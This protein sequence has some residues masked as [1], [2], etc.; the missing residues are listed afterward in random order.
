MRSNIVVCG[1]V[2]AFCFS[3]APVGG[4]QRLSQVTVGQSV[5]G[6][7]TPDSPTF[8]GT[9]FQAFEFEAR[10]G[11]T[12][13]ALA[14]ASDFEPEVRIGRWVAGVIDY[15]AT[16]GEAGLDAGAL[17]LITAS[18][19]GRHVV[20]VRSAD[21]RTGD[22]TLQ[23]R[24]PGG[25][26]LPLELGRATA[27]TVGATGESL[28][29]FRGSA[30]QD[31]E[32]VVRSRDFDT[33]LEVGRM[34]N[35][36][37]M[38][39]QQDDDG[40]GGTDSRVYFTPPA[41][42]EYIARVTAYGGGEGGAYA[43]R[44]AVPVELPPARPLTRGAPVVDALG[45][46]GAEVDG[47]YI[48]DWLVTVTAGERIQFDLESDEFDAYLQI[49][50]M[51]GRRFVEV[52]SNDDHPDLG[53]TDAR[54]VLI[55]TADGEY[56][57]RVRS[58]SSGETG[59]YTLTATALD[60][61]L[62][63]PRGGNLTI[64]EEVAGTLTSTDAILE[65]GTPYQEWVLNV[66]GPGRYEF[67]LRSDDFDTFLVVGT[68]ERDAFMELAVNDDWNESDNGTD[69][70]LVMTLPE[71][72]QYRVRVRPFSRGEGNYRL[73]VRDAGAVR[74]EPAGGVIQLGQAVVSV[75][76][77]GDARLADDAPYHEWA[78]RAPAGATVRIELVSE[79]F[80][81]RLSVGRRTNGTYVEL[82]EDD[83]SGGGTNSRIDF[84]PPAEGEYVIRASPLFADE[85]GEYRL[86]VDLL[87]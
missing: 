73:V 62:V 43:I 25:G 5:Q 2:A 46:Q 30:G 14:Q 56:I 17:A 50:R 84:V 18:E 4:Q 58:Y 65:D 61:V 37:F 44:V 36:N 24:E 42:G 76:E 11:V 77:E 53:G 7:L 6:R 45:P 83:D 15:V 38:S 87:P 1:V 57:V 81:A 21:E 66:G 75:I 47:Y 9:P 39:L 82:A 12:Y 3:A 16:G 33:Y 86:R 68:G 19:S 22:F 27:G 35:G 69:S 31:L 41:T 72:G 63:E 52:A 20:V 23:V 8:A 59:S 54:A 49:G 71:A 85:R 48:A 26:V 29:S 32:I 80:D 70:R 78:F 74:S 60:P 51:D 67:L 55:A 13:E 28:N 79:A 40:A 10:E 64:G 34:S